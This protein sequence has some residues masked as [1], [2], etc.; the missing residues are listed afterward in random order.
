MALFVPSDVA[1][2]LTSRYSR[3]ASEAEIERT[4]AALRDNG[5]DARVVDDGE[6]AK[7]LVLELIPDGS[8]VHS[9]SSTTLDQIGITEAIANSDRFEAL[10][11]RIWSMDRETQMADIRRLG[12]AP[13][14][15]LGS[16][17]ALTETGS[18]VTA[19]Y[20]GSQLAPYV[21]GAGR[22]I[23]VVGAQKIVPNLEAALERIEQFALPMEDARARNA[24]GMGSAVNSL[25]IMNRQH[26]SRT[27]VIIVREA[28]GF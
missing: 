28:L 24:Y 19:S 27:T 4:V 23:W 14:V 13:D 16:I 3:L 6:A 22:V 2:V 7:A 15:M 20:G 10:R 26:P 21:Y 5:F 8:E 1:E 9:A 25:L 17:H 12:A 11:P 18:A